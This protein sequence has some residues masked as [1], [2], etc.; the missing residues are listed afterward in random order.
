[1]TRDYIGIP[2]DLEIGKY[3]DVVPSSVPANWGMDAFQINNLRSITRGKGMLIGVVD[4]GVDRSHPLLGNVVDALDYSNSRYGANDPQGHG[5]H[6]TGTIC[7]TDERIGVGP[8]LSVIMAKGLGDS[9]SGSDQQIAA[10]MRG[11]AS[12]GC[13]IISMSLGSAGP[14]PETDRAGQE[15]EAAGIWIFCAAGNSG[16]RTSDVDFPGRYQWCITVA[17]V[18]P[19]YAPASFTS[20]G[21]K[22]DTS[23]PGTD[24]ISTRSGGGVQSMSGTSMAT[25]FAAGVG[26]LY[27]NAL[28]L[29]NLEVPRVGGLRSLLWSNSIDTHT[30]GFDRR[31]GPGWINP[32]L[33]AL[34]LTP[35][36]PRVSG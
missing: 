32:L 33:L 35:D 6:V 31:T 36:P 4:T 13:K 10:A 11:L 26:G 25:P 17:A 8:E 21:N 30:P 27:R 2:P 20:A 23:G 14:M 12:R 34:D 18:N 9:G 19:Q 3:Y 15:L 22:I 24:I 28:E 1:M 29:R 16:G 5:T 7:A